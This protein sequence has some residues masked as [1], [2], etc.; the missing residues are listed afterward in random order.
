MITGLGGTRAGGGKGKDDD[1]FIAVD[2]PHQRSVVM[3]E[4]RRG[5]EAR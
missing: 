4:S 2:D 1:G 5:H 3:G